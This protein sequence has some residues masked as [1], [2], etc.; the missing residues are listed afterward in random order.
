MVS[1]WDTQF[2]VAFPTKDDWKY[3]STWEIIEKS[4]CHLVFA[5]YILG[6]TSVLLPRPGCGRG[7]LDWNKIR[8]NLRNILDNRFTVIYND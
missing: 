5:A 7:G 8:P 2:L 6:W 1:L 3:P 4:A